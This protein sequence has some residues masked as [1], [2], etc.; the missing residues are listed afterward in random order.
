MTVK[1]RKEAWKEADKLFPTDYEKDEQSSINAGYPIYKS[2]AEGVNAWISDLNTT[3]ELN[4]PDGKTIRINVQ[5]DTDPE[6]MEERKWHTD[7]VRMTCCNHQWYDKGTV[8]EYSKM[9]DF[10]KDNDATGLNIFKVADDIVEHTAESWN[11]ETV[12]FYLMQDACF[13]YFK[14]K[15]T[16]DSVSE[17]NID[18]MSTC[19]EW[20][21]TFLNEDTGKVRC[22]CFNAP[23]ES[24]A[25]HNFHECY[26]H[27]R[28]KILS[29]V[30]TGRN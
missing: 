13:T 26:R 1:S 16:I 18:D 22:D 4:L 3:I 15:T 23:T 28:Y 7:N 30:L 27:H 9:L 12:M 25:K 20:V 11:I 10:V 17:V 21:V 5:T 14:V 6:I 29:C 2:T 8:E 19:P 24:A